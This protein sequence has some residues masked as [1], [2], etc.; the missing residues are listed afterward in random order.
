MLAKVAH[1]LC[2]RVRVGR[3]KGRVRRGRCSFDAVGA[4]VREGGSVWKVRVGRGG[5]FLLVFY[6][7]GCVGWGEVCACVCV[8]MYVCAY[9]S[10]SFA[11]FY[12]GTM[13]AF[14]QRRSRVGTD[15]RNS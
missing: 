14:P 2:W 7:G 12:A 1:Q 10:R 15:M 4:A 5:A 3:L 9:M 13:N 6:D 8:C 11:V